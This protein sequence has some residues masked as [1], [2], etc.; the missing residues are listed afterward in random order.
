MSKAVS[1]FDWELNFRKKS[2][3]GH[4]SDIE[5]KSIIKKEEVNSLG[6]A[7]N[8]Y[9]DFMKKWKAKNF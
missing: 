2:Q 1:Y 8:N 3:L 5:T 4:N 6:I 7:D 9:K